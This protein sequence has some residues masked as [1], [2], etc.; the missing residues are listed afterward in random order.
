MPLEIPG[1]SYH[2]HDNYDFQCQHCHRF[3]RGFNTKIAGNTEIKI[4]PY[5]RGVQ[6]EAEKKIDA[7]A[8][9]GT[10]FCPE[11]KETYSGSRVTFLGGKPVCV[12][13]PPR[14]PRLQ[15]VL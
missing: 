1:P 4:C 5:C 8:N 6:R 15:K 7:N 12:N 9:S 13:H 10:Y 14:M 3:P 2:G 11:C